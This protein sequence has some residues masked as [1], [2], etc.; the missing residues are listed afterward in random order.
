MSPGSQQR[1]YGK[2]P[3]PNITV[4]RPPSL[5]TANK[6]AK[7]YLQNNKVVIP[8]RKVPP[9]NQTR[10]MTSHGVSPNANNPLNNQKLYV[11]MASLPQKRN[12]RPVT[13]HPQSRTQHYQIQGI[14]ETPPQNQNGRPGTGTGTG[15]SYL[16]NISLISQRK[17]GNREEEPNRPSESELGS[18]VERFG[19]DEEE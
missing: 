1:K 18:D 14:N 5:N 9:M 12:E 6:A 16:L 3:P 4:K 10:P 13:A 15:Y 8:R 2:S 7:A 17:R 19:L 11:P